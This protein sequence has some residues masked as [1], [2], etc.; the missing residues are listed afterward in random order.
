M[1]NPGLLAKYACMATY[2]CFN[3]N[4]TY[5]LIQKSSLSL[6]LTDSF[7]SVV[8]GAS[9]LRGHLNVACRG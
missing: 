4:N 3:A 6:I 9:S 5:L 7:S 2:A 8:R 1:S